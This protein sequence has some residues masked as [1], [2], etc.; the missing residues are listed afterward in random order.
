MRLD[1][2]IPQGGAAA[3]G[4]LIPLS[5]VVWRDGQPWVFVKTGA[6][7]F[8]RRP[9]GSRSE[10]GE[11]WFVAQGFAPGEEA[12]VVGGQMLLS[13]EQRRAAPKDSGGD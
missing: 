11:A 5:A 1:A 12:V 10:H 3:A 4:V 9:L 2:W 8:A 7:G 6:A 13:E